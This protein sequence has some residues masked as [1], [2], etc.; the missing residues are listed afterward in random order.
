MLLFGRLFLDESG[1]LRPTKFF[2][3]VLSAHR[4]RLGSVRFEI[5]EVDRRP[6]ASV[7]GPL[8][9]VVLV[10]A[11]LGVGS[12]ARI[13]AVVG[14]PQDVDVVAAH[15]RRYRSTLKPHVVAEK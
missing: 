7:F 9:R 14:T 5:D 8:A 6:P 12:V 2:D 15:G 1:F 10:E 13:E 11:P 4:R 3:L